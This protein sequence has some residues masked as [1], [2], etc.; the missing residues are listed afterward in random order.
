MGSLGGGR[1]ERDIDINRADPSVGKFLGWPVAGKSA[2][3]SQNYRG[4]LHTGIDI[5]DKNIAELGDIFCWK[6]IN[7]APLWAI[8]FW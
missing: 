7:I 4:R 6:N 8:L 5:A 2:K 1:I 3:I